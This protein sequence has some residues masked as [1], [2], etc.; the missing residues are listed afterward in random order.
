MNVGKVFRNFVVANLFAVLP[1]LGVLL[2]WLPDQ[3]MIR[4]RGGNEVPGAIL[5]NGAALAGKD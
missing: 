2:G 1:L 4:M 5:A 3:V